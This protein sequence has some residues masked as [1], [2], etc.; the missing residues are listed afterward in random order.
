VI[1][2]V[3]GGPDSTALMILA[4]R[5]RSTRPRGP[6]LVAATV[7]H[8]L[9]KESAAEAEAVGKLARSLRIA[10]H[11]LVWAGKK[12]SSGLQ[13]VAR[14][15]RYRL[16]MDL[17]KRIG[18]DAIATAHTRDDQAETVLLRL[19][20]GSGLT[21]LAAIRSAG[22]RDG[23]VLL[24]PLLDVPK[25]RL[26]A[27]LK[28]A[29]VAFAEDPSNIDPR[30]ARVRLRRLAPMLAGEG[31]DAGRLAQLAKRLARAD[32]ALAST[33][34]AAE[35]QV[36]LTAPNREETALNAVALFAFPD[37]IGMRLL[38][39]AIDRHGD[40]GPIELGKLETLFEALAASYAAG[41]AL[42]RTLA[43]ATVSMAGPRIA[44]ARAPARRSRR[45]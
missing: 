6:E 43:G 13:A 40:E 26:I 39:R 24:R 37:E 17:A 41:R 8:R 4:A 36:L 21:G 16:L 18:A 19:A 3:S 10:H 30:F 20:R 1:L 23:I 38:G 32:A 22:E 14:S 5:W 34:D 27:T 42:K 44:V 9:R 45:V 12:P 11:T 29:R 28:N 25:V 31:I 7:D 35:T 33:V 2:A 15:A